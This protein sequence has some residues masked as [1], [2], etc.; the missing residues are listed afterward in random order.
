MCFQQQ[1][2]EL[3]QALYYS[4]QKLQTTSANLARLQAQFYHEQQM[5]NMF[6]KLMDQIIEKSSIEMESG[7]N[8]VDFLNDL[9]EK[10]SVIEDLESIVHGQQKVLER[11]S[12]HICEMQ[13]F[14]KQ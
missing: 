6:A 8:T 9:R 13:R 14:F 1:N 4:D 12:Y 3:S 5:N 11:Q 10:Q 7:R 2:T